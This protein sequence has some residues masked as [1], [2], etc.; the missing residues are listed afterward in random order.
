MR[1]VRVRGRL[2]LSSKY[3]HMGIA[4]VFLTPVFLPI[5]A[6][7]VLGGIITTSANACMDA[8]LDIS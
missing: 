4:R 2:Y 7:S 1:L 3:F 8:L 6:I 5:L